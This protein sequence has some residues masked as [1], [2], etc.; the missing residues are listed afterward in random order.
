MPRSST[1]R[2][3]RW[4][5]RPYRP[6][7]HRRGS[8]R[9]WPASRC[10]RPRPA[11]AAANWELVPGRIPQGGSRGPRHC[12]QLPTTATRLELRQ[13]TLRASAGRRLRPQTCSPGRPWHY[14]ACPRTLAYPDRSRWRRALL[15]WAP[16]VP[17][18]LPQTALHGL[19]P[20]WRVCSSWQPRRVDRRRI[21][22]LQPPRQRPGAPP[23]RPNR[24][25]PARIAAWPATPTARLRSRPPR[26]SSPLLAA[27]EAKRD[28]SRW[29]RAS[30]GG[31]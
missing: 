9:I 8:D 2:P 14:L 7:P 23:R 21:G 29:R 31:L 26:R 28:R 25:A 12:R 3:L 27:A 30:A 24:P 15:R 19:L 1:R 10:H 11:G 13:R 16:V 20:G 5:R 6:S 22:S 4:A 18:C 17:T